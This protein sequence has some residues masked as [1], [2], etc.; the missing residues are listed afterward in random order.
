MR[1]KEAKL[2]ALPMIRSPLLPVNRSHLSIPLFFRINAVGTIPFQLSLRINP[3]F[4]VSRLLAIKCAN[5]T[6]WRVAPCDGCECD[7]RGWLHKQQDGRRR[8]S[9]GSLP[10]PPLG[11][12]GGVR[13]D[14][15]LA[16]G[17]KGC[18]AKGENARVPCQFFPN[19][20]PF[21]I[22]AGLGRAAKP[23]TTPYLPTSIPLSP[24]LPRCTLGNPARFRDC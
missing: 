23:T 13:R 11:S 6:R 7:G 17:R 12:A 14:A 3:L 8:G 5:G 24:A 9:F 16:R 19:V 21:E 22:L 15:S 2:G 1:R 4:D 18:F 20:W 10:R